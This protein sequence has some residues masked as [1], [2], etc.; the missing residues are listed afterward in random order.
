MNPTSLISYLKV[1]QWIGFLGMALPF[2]LMIGGCLAGNTVLP[3]ISDYYYSNMGTVFSGALFAVAT[4]LLTYKGYDNSKSLLF[5]LFN[6]NTATNLCSFFA[7][8]VALFPC[9]TIY[10]TCCGEQISIIQE[11]INLIHFVSAALLFTLLGAISFYFFTQSDK[12]KLEL[13]NTRKALRNKIY[14][15][16]GIIIWLSILAMGATKLMIGKPTGI[17]DKYVLIG[18]IICLFAFGFSWLVKGET[19]L[20]DKV[21][22]SID[23]NKLTNNINL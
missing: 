19:M 4:F 23:N 17:G 2:V 10:T 14:K 6:D 7:I 5:G 11:T 8:C 12:P 20:K 9:N 18:E 21:K 13:R 22:P 3:S 16:C 15:A 1:R